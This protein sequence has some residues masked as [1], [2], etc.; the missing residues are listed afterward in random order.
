MGLKL[1]VA[2]ALDR[3]LGSAASAPPLAPPGHP[4]LFS[5]I[6]RHPHPRSCPRRQKG[7]SGAFD[8][9]LGSPAP[10]GRE[11]EN[12]QNGEETPQSLM[13]ALVDYRFLYF[14]HQTCLCISP[15]CEKNDSEK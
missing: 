11:I 14:N 3:T 15:F 1:A 12:L 2:G 7:N 9:A 4:H 6:R 8:R 13:S 5:W 10:A